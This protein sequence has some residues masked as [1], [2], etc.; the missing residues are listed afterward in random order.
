M[1]RIPISLL[2]GKFLHCQPVD[3]GPTIEAQVI[4]SDTEVTPMFKVAIV[5]PA[6]LSRSKCQLRVEARS[7]GSHCLYYKG[8]SRGDYQI[9]GPGM[10]NKLF[11]G[12][13]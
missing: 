5:C 13:K 2:Q 3:N 7:E 8:D 9:I 4:P 6:R 10:D 1:E 11:D 12:Y